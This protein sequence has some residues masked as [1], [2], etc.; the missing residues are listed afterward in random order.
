MFQFGSYRITVVLVTS[1]LMLSQLVSPCFR[2]LE[3]VLNCSM[4]YVVSFVLGC[5]SLYD[6][7][8]CCYASSVLEIVLFSPNV[9]VPFGSGYIV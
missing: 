8:H 5:F 4:F 6:I 9:V 7:V 1:V 2:L 3:L